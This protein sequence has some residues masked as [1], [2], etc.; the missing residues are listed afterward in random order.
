M[1]KVKKNARRAADMHGDRDL[2]DAGNWRA[3]TGD[4]DARA[5]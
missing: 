3:E 5:S 1:E 4:L 2:P